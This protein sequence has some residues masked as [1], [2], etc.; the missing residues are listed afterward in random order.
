MDIHKILEAPLPDD[1]DSSKFSS[2]NTFKDRIEYAKKM[3]QRIGGGSSRIAFLIKYKNRD[4]ILK[5]AKNKKGMVQNERESMAFND[6]SMLGVEGTV[7]VPMID[8]DEKNSQPTWLHVEYAPKLKSEKQFRQLSG[9]FE[10]EDILN[11]AAKLTNNRSILGANNK[12]FSNEFTD[13]IWE[14]EGSFAYE[15]VNFIGNTDTHLADLRRLS[16]WGAYNNNPVIIDLGVDE[17]ILKKF[18]S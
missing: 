4:T 2:N 5:V 9:G 11:Y 1:W 16:N 12:T 3:A 7:T 8:Y 6:A 14:A 10:L 17:Q 13:K 15:L 18:Y